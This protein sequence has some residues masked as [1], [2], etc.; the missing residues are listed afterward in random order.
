MFS[1]EKAGALAWAADFPGEYTWRDRLLSRWWWQWIWGGQ[2]RKYGGV[3]EA[4][5]A[6]WEP[7]K[8]TG[9]NL[10]TQRPAPWALDSE[11]ISGI[12]A[13]LW[14]GASARDLALWLERNL[15]DPYR[16]ETNLGELEELATRLVKCYEE[17]VLDRN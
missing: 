12:L 6:S 10:K 9:K 11:L 8:W 1:A 14:Q 4:V 5:L 16:I 15:A 2:R 17:Q 3:I 13:V 7:A